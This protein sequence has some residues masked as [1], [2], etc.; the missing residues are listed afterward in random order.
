MAVVT[1]SSR[2]DNDEKAEVWLLHIPKLPVYLQ[3]CVQIQ[4]YIITVDL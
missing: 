3:V 2:L 1:V 4:I